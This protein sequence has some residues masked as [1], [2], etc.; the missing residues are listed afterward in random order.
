MDMYLWVFC[1]LSEVSQLDTPEEWWKLS[2]CS[3]ELLKHS[4][5]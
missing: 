1:I 3:V 5:W 4:L 2:C